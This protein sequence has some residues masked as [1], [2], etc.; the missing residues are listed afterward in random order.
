MKPKMKHVF[1]FGNELKID[2]ENDIIEP[3]HPLYNGFDDKDFRGLR[4]S[5]RRCKE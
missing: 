2:T 4:N 1:T 5:P 3:K